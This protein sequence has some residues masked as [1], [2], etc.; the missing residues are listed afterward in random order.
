MLRLMLEE[1]IATH[2]LQSGPL[3]QDPRYTA[4]VIA[5]AVMRR[6]AEAGWRLEHD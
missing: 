3:P 2:M 5:A 4:R 6:L 1:E